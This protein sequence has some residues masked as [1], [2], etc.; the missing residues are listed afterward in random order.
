VE[1][2]ALGIAEL[3]GALRQRIILGDLSHHPDGIIEVHR[4]ALV[5]SPFSAIHK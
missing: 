1:C 5:C 2:D 3:P 4:S